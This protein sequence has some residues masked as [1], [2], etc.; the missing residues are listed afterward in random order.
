MNVDGVFTPKMKTAL[1][2]AGDAIRDC[3]EGDKLDRVALETLYDAF[4]TAAAHNTNQ[5]T[6]VGFITDGGV[7]DM[8]L[9]GMIVRAVSC[10]R[11]CS[12]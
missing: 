10:H 12:P 11:A 6:N 1:R 5:N 3:P 2:Q 4:K 8:P 9:F 7:L